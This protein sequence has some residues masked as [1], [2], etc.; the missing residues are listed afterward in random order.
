MEEKLIKLLEEKGPEIAQK[1]QLSGEQVYAKL[2]WYVRVDGVAD[3]IQLL[4]IITLTIIGGVISWSVVKV[5]SG[6]KELDDNDLGGI[7][8]FSFV[9]FLLALIFTTLLVPAIFKIF[10]PEYSLI[11][12]ILEGVTQ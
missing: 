9:G 7:A 11:K 2:L 4:S 8:I 1:L 5:M 10:V 12:Q 6:E 3:I